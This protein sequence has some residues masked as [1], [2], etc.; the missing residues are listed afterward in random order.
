MIY[1]QFNT[2]YCLLLLP[3]CGLD[4]F[5]IPFL[6]FRTDHSY[7]LFKGFIIYHAFCMGYKIPFCIDKIGGRK[8]GYP[9][10]CCSRIVYIIIHREGIVIFCYMQFLKKLLFFCYYN[11]LIESGFFREF[12]FDVPTAI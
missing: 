6:L 3:F 1:K 4:F 9:I 2:L 8:G 10:C 11:R 7:S 5:Y 12:P